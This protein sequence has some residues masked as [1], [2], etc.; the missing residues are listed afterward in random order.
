MLRNRKR[1]QKASNRFAQAT[2]RA[3]KLRKQS[4]KAGG[5]RVP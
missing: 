1:K 4:A 2:K 3:K 5:A